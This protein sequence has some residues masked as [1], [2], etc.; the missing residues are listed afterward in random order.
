L[1][2]GL[3]IPAAIVSIEQPAGSYVDELT[4][5][6]PT[7][8]VT[9]RRA[10]DASDGRKLGW[11]ARFGVS[12]P[13]AEHGESGA[14]FSNRALAVASAFEAWREQESYFPGRWS[15]TPSG[16]IDV[17]TRPW[18]FEASLKLPLLVEVSDANL[19]EEAEAHAV[20]FAPVVH[21]RAGVEA[22]RWL[23]PSLSADLVVNAVSPVE[24]A[25][26][27]IST[28]QLVLRP[29]LDFPLG[30]GW[31]LSADF[32]AP[33]AGSLGGSTFSGSLLVATSF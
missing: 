21:T 7:L 27:E 19:P 14:L 22:L 32:V 25:R 18:T 3:V 13:L 9:H 12:L 6:N 29:A 11:F 15:F 5:G 4:W 17:S 20:G 24:G 30:R 23:I 8:S 2:L 1:E 16:G 31:I 33:V 26:D 10:L 28:I